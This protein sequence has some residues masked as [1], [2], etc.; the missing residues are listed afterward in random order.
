LDGY[1]GQTF[2]QHAQEREALMK[3]VE[4]AG[5]G[6]VDIGTLAR[7]QQVERDSPFGFFALFVDRLHLSPE[8]VALLADQLVAP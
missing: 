8:G 7:Q 5:F 6:W 2:P 1:F 3:A 4:A